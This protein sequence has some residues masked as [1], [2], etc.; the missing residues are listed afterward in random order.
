MTCHRFLFGETPSRENVA[1]ERRRRQVARTP[2][3]RT[4]QYDALPHEYHV[5]SPL[6][7]WYSLASNP[8]GMVFRKAV[9]RAMSEMQ[10]FRFRKAV[11]FQAIFCI[12]IPLFAVAIFSCVFYL[13]P[14]ANQAHMITCLMRVAGVLGTALFGGM[15]LLFLYVIARKRY[16][17]L[18]CWLLPAS[19]VL[20][21]LFWWGPRGADLLHLAPHDRRLLAAAAIQPPQA[22]RAFGQ[23]DVRPWR[24]F[25][26][27]LVDLLAA[28]ADAA[29]RL[30]A[31]GGSRGHV[32][33]NPVLAFSCRS[34]PRALRGCEGRQI[35]HHRRTPRRRN[36]Q[37]GM[38]SRR[39]GTG[40]CGHGVDRRRIASRLGVR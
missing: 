27:G 32:R 23:S 14:P 2:R 19:I 7:R 5:E 17:R 40:R 28:V 3:R 36:G 16:D 15:L 10:T 11:L 25:F 38:A 26:C 4:A 9:A 12:P 33:F 1:V 18:A 24:P 13:P 37:R 29:S 22:G 35:G 21:L 20:A 8:A 30:G 31:C 34:A 39:T 6:P